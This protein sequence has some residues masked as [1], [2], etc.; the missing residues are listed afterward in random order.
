VSPEQSVQTLPDLRD[1]LR[2][3]VWP[4][5]Q[6]YIS[7]RTVL[8]ADKARQAL[9]RSKVVGLPRPAHLTVAEPEEA[10]C[11]H[12]VQ[13]VLL[14]C[15]QCPICVIT[16]VHE[17]TSEVC[18]PHAAT[19][20]Q[21]SHLFRL[22]CLTHCAKE[23]AHWSEARLHFLI[24]FV[25]LQFYSK[26]RSAGACCMW[27]V[28]PASSMVACEVLIPA[29]SV[30][31]AGMRTAQQPCEHAHHTHTRFARILQWAVG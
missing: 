23:R 15:D 2:P 21:L 31:D 5:K 4:Q 7:K 13:K 9:L 16:A 12:A 10:S 25:A 26:G 24:K 19:R 14:V 8:V 28:I 18:M 3:G 29:S 30:D 6:P 11:R 1:G 20:Y 27:V 22:S 17:D